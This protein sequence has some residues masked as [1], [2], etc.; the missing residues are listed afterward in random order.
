MARKTN[1][2]KEF[3]KFYKSNVPSY[4]ISNTDKYRWNHRNS[5]GKYTWAYVNV[6]FICWMGAKQNNNQT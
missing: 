3:E 2:Q 1:D 4:A 6:G 5:K